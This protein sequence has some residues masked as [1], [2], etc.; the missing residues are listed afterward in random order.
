MGRTRERVHLISQLDLWFED[1]YAE[2]EADL[3]RRFGTEADQPRRIK[4]KKLVR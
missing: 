4:Y 3:K 1:N 2:Y